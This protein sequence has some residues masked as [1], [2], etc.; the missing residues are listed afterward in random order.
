MQF[1]T[2]MEDLD[3]VKALLSTG[4]VDCNVKIKV[5][6]NITCQK[7]INFIWFL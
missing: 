5:N 1:S 2:S 4:D 6:P 3:A 7:K